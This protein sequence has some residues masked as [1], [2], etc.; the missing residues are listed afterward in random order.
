MAPRVALGFRTHLGWAA[1]VA[2]GGKPS[3]PRVIARR[4][5][6]LADPAVPESLD[7]YHAARGLDPVEAEGVVHQGSEAALAVTRHAVRAAVDE[8]RADGCQVVASCVLMAGGRMPPTLD[9]ILASHAMVHVA[10][11]RLF[12]RAVSEASE[13]CSLPVVGL[14]ER[15]AFERAA[16]VLRLP[17]GELGARIDRLGRELGPPWQKDQKLAAAAAWFCLAGTP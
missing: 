6:V 7:P 13:R 14:P 11:G 10:E 12:R 17:A 9:R 8:L 2:L 5:L 1:M 3:D 4:R 16:D 15:E